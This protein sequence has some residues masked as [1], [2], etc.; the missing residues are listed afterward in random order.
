MEVTCDFLTV[1]SDLP[2]NI[3]QV[4]NFY[5]T[6]YSFSVENQFLDKKNYGF[7]KKICKL[8]IKTLFHQQIFKRSQF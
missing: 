1:M 8:G 6:K 7:R 3:E 4:P 2:F 5:K